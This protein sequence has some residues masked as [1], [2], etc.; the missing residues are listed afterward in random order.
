MTPATTPPLG[1]SGE[2]SWPLGQISLMVSLGDEE[3]SMSALMNFIV[4]RSPS[5]YNGIIGRPSIRKIQAVSSTTHKMIKFLVKEGIVMLHSN[6][7]IPTECRMVAEAPN[8]L[9]PNEP[10]A[11]KGIKVLET[12]RHNRRSKVHSGTPPEH[13]LRMSADKAK[14]KSP[15]EDQH[16]TKPQ[17]MHLRS[18]RRDV[19]GSHCKH[20]GNKSMSGKGKSSH[21]TAFTKNAERG[22]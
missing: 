1:F 21:E 22:T 16:E 14:E 2:I 12:S 8:E 7:I 10:A 6:T 3:H 17:D 9:L 13:P 4:V 15:K 5:L 18:R 19:P 20:E 11:T